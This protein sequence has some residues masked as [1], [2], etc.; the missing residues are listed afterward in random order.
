MSRNGIEPC[1]KSEQEGVEC[2][3]GLLPE[4]LPEIEAEDGVKLAARCRLC[5][6]V[7][8]HYLYRLTRYRKPWGIELCG[9]CGTVCDEY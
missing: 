5:T 9:I 7:S 3:C 6:G 4:G 8:D 2:M 1:L